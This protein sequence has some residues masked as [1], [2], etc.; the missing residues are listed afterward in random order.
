MMAKD[1]ES[2]S[3]IVV[4]EQGDRSLDGIFRLIEVAGQARGLDEVLAA[5][6]TEVSA[7]A[8]SAVVSIYVR[9]EDAAGPV[10]T[11]RGNVG[12]PVDAIG[13]VR[14]RVGEGIIGFVADRLRPVSVT[15]ADADEHFKYIPGLGEERFPALLA[16]PVLR[17][18]G[19]TGVLVLQRG[20]T[21]SFAA[22]EVV[23]A[24]ALAAV[25]SHALERAEGRER[26][27][28]T[29]HGVA[30]LR[31][32]SLSGGAAMGRAEVLPTLAALSYTK[33]PA[34]PNPLSLEVALQR[35]QSE[36]GKAVQRIGGP[37]ARELGTLALILEDRRFRER[38]SAAVA[39]PSPLPALSD[40]AREYA[41]VAF[42]VAQNDHAT[43]DA[44]AE[45]AAEI[46]DLCVL[47]HAATTG[48]PLV[49]TGAIVVVENLRAF[50]VLNAISR[51]ASAFVV[52]GDL[53]V[54]GAVA[55]I[56]REA[57]VPLLGS[58]T[59]VFSWVRPDHL[60]VVD[61]DAGTIRVNP[62]ATTVARFRNTRG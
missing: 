18:M 7:I 20:P 13:R 22:E 32:V 27:R 55:A 41:R 45:R 39:A 6:C 33:V 9:E 36:V 3:S 34:G 28:Q 60:L 11:M 23:L 17:G 38:L 57:G 1:L 31:G 62:E 5:M 53:P 25:I 42:R 48:R 2:D 37:L 26:D 16:V 10:F 29:D 35:L 56:V 58:V 15:A 49:R 21:A 50:M 46:E 44:M 24:T 4:H 54:D 8:A 59:G 30:R 40:V 12:F 19:A 43:A 47:V 52:D 61:A 14:L 51:G